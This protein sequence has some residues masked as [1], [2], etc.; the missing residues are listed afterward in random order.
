MQ[1]S[2]FA[3]NT[4]GRAGSAVRPPVKD[5][6]RSLYQPM[7]SY[8]PMHIRF[9]FV[10]VNSVWKPTPTLPLLY[11]LSI[12]FFP[13]APPPTLDSVLHACQT[14]TLAFLILNNCVCVR[15]GARRMIYSYFIHIIILLKMFC[16]F[17]CLFYI[18]GTKTETEYQ[19]S[20]ILVFAYSINLKFNMK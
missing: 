6:S 5:L 13:F 1:L 19:L 17:V 10:I 16:L 7:M 2:L 4:R 11:F 9:S 12:F 3:L 15:G 8:F 14:S 20:D 18:Y